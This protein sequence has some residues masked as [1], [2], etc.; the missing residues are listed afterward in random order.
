MA[1]M[2]GYVWENLDDYRPIILLNTTLKI[3]TCVLAKRLPLVISD[4]IGPEENYV[5]KG[6]SI[7]D[8]LHLVREVLDEL[9]RADQFELVQGLQ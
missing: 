7:Q 5:V 1:G 9:S 6:R 4:L 8:N 2:F 3:L